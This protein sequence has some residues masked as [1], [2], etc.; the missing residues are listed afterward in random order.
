MGCPE[1]DIT[2]YYRFT[3][4]SEK[5]HSRG[6]D[7]TG[8]TAYKAFFFKAGLDQETGLVY[9]NY[10]YLSSELGRWLSRDPIGI[11]GGINL[12][13]HVTNNPISKIDYLGL[14]ETCCD[15]G[16][17]QKKEVDS[18][19]CSNSKG[20]SS[21]SSSG[22]KFNPCC[23]FKIEFIAVDPGG[24]MS[25][26]ATTHRN[27]NG[28]P[29]AESDWG[30]TYLLTA[31]NKKGCE[32]I[33][34]ANVESWSKTK[35]GNSRHYDEEKYMGENQPT[36]G[37]GHKIRKGYGMVGSNFQAGST[38]KVQWSVGGTTC[39]TYNFTVSSVSPW[40]W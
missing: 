35:H 4:P 20:T 23:C 32:K 19:C 3:E 10:R 15:M 38:I 7:S 25:I 14:A 30:L 22:G 36:D 9:Y 8:K 5:V 37:F 18:S 1:L 39:K 2:S 33:D 16:N 29:V 12:Y 40:N 34:R 26:G 31:T 27:W 13:A 11:L 24:F 28:K 6:C 21:S 17:G